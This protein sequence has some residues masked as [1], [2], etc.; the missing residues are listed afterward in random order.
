MKNLKDTFDKLDVC[1][2]CLTDWEPDMDQFGCWNCG[3]EK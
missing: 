3:Y 2:Y 1:P